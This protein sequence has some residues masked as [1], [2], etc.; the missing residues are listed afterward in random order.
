MRQ[1]GKTI[2][3]RV[4][5]M[6]A[7]LSITLL[8]AVLL[9]AC[10]GSSSSSSNNNNNT[11]Q[12]G[13]PETR[14][15]MANGCYSLQSN[16]TKQYAAL[17][18]STLRMDS[19]KTS[20]E[21]FYMRP[22]TLG[23][24]LLYTSDERF[25]TASGGNIT[26][27]TE[28]SDDAIWTIERDASA[29]TFS[30]Q[31][32]SGQTLSVAADG[33]LSTGDAGGA[34][35]QFLFA[36]TA[37]CSSYPEMPT[38]VAGET[39]KGRGID[40]PAIG[41]ADIHNH[42][43]MSSE[44]SYAGDVGPS[45]G[46]VLYGEAFHRFG[47]THALEDCE[48]LHGPNGI[49]GPDLIL[50]TGASPNHETQGWP[51]FVDWPRNKSLSHT[52]L[53]YRWVERAWLAGLRLMV[54]HGTNIAGLCTVGSI[55]SLTPDADCNDMSIAIKQIKYMYD[56]QDYV[57]AQHGGPGKGWYRIVTSP[58]QAREVIN[59]GK[60][61]VVLGMEAAQVFDCGMTMIAGNIEIPKCDEAQIDA[62]LQEL[63]DLGVRHLY[64]Y[65]DIDTALG[66]TGLFSDIMNFLNL[67]DTGSFWKTSECRDYP[68]EEPT[69][70]DPGLA[71]A[72]ALPGSGND[73][74]SSMVLDIT[75]GALPI[76]PEGLRCNARTVT[77][78]GNY[79]LNAMMD[80]GMVMDIDHAAYHS[81]DIMLD[82]A[83]QR[84]PAYPMVSSHDAHGGLTS[85][86]AA[87]ILKSGGVIYPYKGNGVKH[88]EFM[89]KLKFWR[90]KAGVSDSLMALGYGADGNGFGGHAG[91]RG[92]DSEPVQY[93]FV[94]FQG[95]DWGPQFQDAEPVTVQM[96]TIPESGKYWHIDEVG[97][98]HYGLV[99]DY[100]EEVRLEGG[101]EAIDAL[102]NSAEAYLQTWERS[103]NPRNAQ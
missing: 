2:T 69:V 60:L 3:T 76:Y 39:F 25:I 51:T 19:A 28:P 85:D 98:A 79:A 13:I 100:V 22:A 82:L 5:R 65:H 34:A 52:V 90:E 92:G 81:K 12:R 1:E 103:Y 93:P 83:E 66:G 21:R 44:L 62:K 67:L 70:R 74:L 87:R 47:V 30:L 73:P 55:Y 99:A 78:L 20:A 6:N 7:K 71:I 84:T 40:Q 45:A 57:D 91:P 68:S 4:I 24:Y 63:W 89:E 8:A 102:F 86:Q 32:H 54:N 43:G 94:L 41:F 97:M 37:G 59:E 80:R 61:A 58:Q 49:R 56:I 9:A 11:S 35:S 72:T 14:F 46:G 42:M 50:E 15:A 77:E 31:S 48:E 96:L 33:A 38:S 26:A 16:A 101:Q 27:A 29:K 75:G 88:K 17:S 23:K 18:D 53:Y 95:D 10:G 36:P 64:A